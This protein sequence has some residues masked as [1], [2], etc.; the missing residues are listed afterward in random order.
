V[1]TEVEQDADNYQYNVI[2]NNHQQQ[3]HNN[4]FNGINFG[5]IV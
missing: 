2:I 1:S 3:D 4:G 5:I